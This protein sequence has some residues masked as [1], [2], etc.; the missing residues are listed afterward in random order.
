MLKLGTP[1]KTALRRMATVGESF[2]GKMLTGYDVMTSDIAGEDMLHALTQA[3][4]VFLAEGD[5]T[6]IFNG[7]TNFYNNQMQKLEI[8]NNLVNR[9]KLYNRTDFTYQDRVYIEQVLRKVGIREV[10]SFLKQLDVLIKEQDTV[11]SQLTFFE[12]TL[13]EREAL[14]KETNRIRNE[15]AADNNADNKAAAYHLHQSI[16]NRLHMAENTM[17]VYNVNKQPY[18]EY[19]VSNIEFKM[20]DQL[21]FLSELKLQNIKNEVMES[22]SPVTYVH[23]NR[24]EN[25]DAL[26]EITNEEEVM[27]SLIEA[28][29]M[30]LL[31]NTL[32]LY[33]YKAYGASDIWVDI[34][35][36]L[37]GSVEN[38]ISRFMLN[39]QEPMLKTTLNTLFGQELSN[40]NETAAYIE[41]FSLVEQILMQDGNFN[42]YQEGDSQ[43]INNVNLAIRTLAENRKKKGEPVRAAEQIFVDRSTNIENQSKNFS[44]TQNNE[45]VNQE[46]IKLQEQNSEQKV[47]QERAAE[48]IKERLKK[49]DVSENAAAAEYMRTPHPEGDT[50]E[51]AVTY[52]NQEESIE[53]YLTQVDQK[54][55]ENARIFNKA[56]NTYIQKLQQQKSEA[57][58]DGALR[59]KKES[60]SAL[61][62]PEELKRI[63]SQESEEGAKAQTVIRQEFIESLPPDIR[64]YMQ[65]YDKYYLNPGPAERAYLK[66]TD[67]F[68]SLMGDIQR[69][70]AQQTEKPQSSMESRERQIAS[71]NEN[72][73]KELIENIA[74]NY[75]TARNVNVSDLKQ[76]S[77][78]FTHRVN[79]EIDQEEILSRL[80]EQRVLINENRTIINQIN[81]DKKVV[82]ETNIT[83]QVIDKIIDSTQISQ[84]VTNSIRGEI[85]ALTDQVYN[86]LERRL[87]N[88]KMR[89]GR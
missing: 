26:T 79:E 34:K 74:V 6:N 17:D 35:N 87:S 63:Y 27:N 47:I 86:K 8:V 42:L 80:N 76:E 22:D 70:K 30:S 83:S 10:N 40:I 37:S 39:L 55:E 14:V 78:A 81:E 36:S 4:E 57:V 48:V 59:Q 23:S 52:L 89:R 54:N 31:E 9:I 18:E 88:E 25:T 65:L 41:E 77:V 60:L 72:I 7:Q 68:S 85:G 75:K 38:I 12:K 45:Y 73:A 51:P 5:T 3:P 21:R 20:A 56:Y 69:V 43:Y 46:L 16:L 62:N 67:A 61:S 53:Q 13:S 49:N 50:A 2:C 32:Q 44:V 19:Y 28:S 64:V 58:S 29:V 15:M 71:R 1:I 24:Y 33:Q 66:N 84:L 11:R 82:N